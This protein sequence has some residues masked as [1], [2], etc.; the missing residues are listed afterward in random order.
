M[1]P[2]K[3]LRVTWK[4]VTHIIGKRHDM[5]HFSSLENLIFYIDVYL[6]CAI[7]DQ[8]IYSNSYM[9]YT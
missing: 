7:K 6:N 4:C 9:I 5:R 1:K 2:G 8:S 3:V